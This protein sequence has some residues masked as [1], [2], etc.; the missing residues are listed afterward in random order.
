MMS[1]RA[2]QVSHIVIRMI[3]LVTLTDIGAVVLCEKFS[4]THCRAFANSSAGRIMTFW[5]ITVSLLL[6]LCVGLEAWWMRKSEA[7]GKS[8]WMDA[9]LAIACFFLLWG[10]VFYSWGHYAMF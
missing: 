4:S 1:R 10:V 3:S 8:L 2:E 6:P 5:T 9:A 7:A